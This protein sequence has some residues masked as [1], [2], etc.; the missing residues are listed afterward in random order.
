MGQKISSVSL[1]LPLSKDWKSKW[2]SKKDYPVLILEDFQIRKSL[3]S[4]FPL[5]TISKIEIDRKRGGDI[6][7]AIY[8]SKPGILI[9]RSG[10]GIEDL[11]NFLEKRINKKIKLEVFEIK[12]PDSDT[13][14]VAENIAW[15]ISRRVAYKRAIKAA[16][17]RAQKA[18]V[19]GIKITVSGR[20]QGAE[21][22]RTETLSFGSI[23][24]QTLRAPV[25]FAAV[26]ALTKFGVIGI[27][28]WIYKK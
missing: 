10:K 8:T 22:A 5:A 26:D 24:S 19:L 2:F 13:V 17:D 28:V 15:Q 14:L 7:I 27:K 4:R 23:P 18:K 6:S 21:I 25:D 9:G 1:R 12:E 11:K 3:K 20:L 16:I